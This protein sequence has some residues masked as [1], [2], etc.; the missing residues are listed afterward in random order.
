MFKAIN[1][2]VGQTVDMFRSRWNNYKDNSRKFYRGEGCIRR[3]LDEHF[4]LP[5]HTGILQDTFVTL[6]D[7]TDPS[8]PTNREDYRIH[9]LK[10]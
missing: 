10:T 6:I 2:H 9:T 3:H 4:Q 5:G 8:A 7:K 1:V